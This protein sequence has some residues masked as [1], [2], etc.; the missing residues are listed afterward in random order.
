MALGLLAQGMTAF[1]AGCVAA[2]L[3]GRLAERLGP[4]LIAEDLPRAIPGLLQELRQ[5]AGQ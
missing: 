4:G 2:W 1:D 5:M 3:H